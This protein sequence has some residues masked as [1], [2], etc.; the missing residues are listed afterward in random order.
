[1][2]GDGDGKEGVTKFTVVNPNVAMD[3]E[4]AKFG[5]FTCQIERL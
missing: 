5:T 4:S 2:E 1:M 3:G